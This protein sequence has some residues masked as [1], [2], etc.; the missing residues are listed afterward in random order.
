MWADHS[1]PSIGPTMHPPNLSL[2]LV[3]GRDSGGLKLGQRSAWVG[4]HRGDISRLTFYLC[5][6][7]KI[8]FKCLFTFET[9]RDRVREGGAERE[10]DTESET[11][12]RL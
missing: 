5:V 6:L 9:E 4:Q 11:G 2:T 8:F 3:P 1:T 7:K 12:S 10:G